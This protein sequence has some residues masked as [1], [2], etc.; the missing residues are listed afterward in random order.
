MKIGIQLDLTE[1]QWLDL[2]ELLREN[3]E[4]N[5]RISSIFGTVSVQM[6]KEGLDIHNWRALTGKPWTRKEKTQ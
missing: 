6:E 3:G 5:R 1:E 4:G 2:L